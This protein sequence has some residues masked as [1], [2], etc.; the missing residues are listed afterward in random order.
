AI[1]GAAS[2]DSAII[3]KLGRVLLLIPVALLFVRWESS[4]EKHLFTKQNISLKS[5]H[6]PWFIIGFLAV[7]LMNTFVIFPTWFVNSALY[8]ST[9][10]LTMGMAG[11]GLGVNF[12]ALRKVGKKFYLLT[13]IGALAIL[14]VGYVGVLLL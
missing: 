14:F 4:K 5:L 8:V 1:G 9:L 7:C 11:L 3:V 6:F 2:A 13:F 10:F 12:S